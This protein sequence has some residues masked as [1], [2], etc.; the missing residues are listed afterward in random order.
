MKVVHGLITAA[1]VVLLRPISTSSSHALRLEAGQRIVSRVPP[2]EPLHPLRIPTGP[3]SVS[4]PI[5]HGYHDWVDPSKTKYSIFDLPQVE[6]WATRK[7]LSERHLKTIYQV[8]M[9][10]TPNTFWDGD[11]NDN[12]AKQNISTVKLATYLKQ[13]DFPHQ[14]ADSFVRDF[15]LTTSQM[16]EQHPSASG[17]TKIVIQ[18]ASGHLIET[19]LIRHDRTSDAR[20]RR[21]R[22]GRRC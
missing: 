1:I 8:V 15:Q 3:V 16:V 7:D 17:G 9:Q 20:P 12:D 22:P 11:T 21:I 18:L 4:E 14:L 6:K 2:L 13:R 5:I 10:S 19:V